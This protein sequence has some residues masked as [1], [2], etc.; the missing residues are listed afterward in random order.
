MKIPKI[1]TQNCYKSKNIPTVKSQDNSVN[2]QAYRFN[3]DCF[4]A[5]KNLSVITKIGAMATAAAV[6]M[7]ELFF[8]AKLHILKTLHK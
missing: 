3:K 8:P 4:T 7:K 6:S 5:K 2:F 1:Q